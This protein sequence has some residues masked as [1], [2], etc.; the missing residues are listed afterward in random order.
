MDQSFCI[1]RL[2]A[3][4]A[5][6]GG[7]SD[8]FNGTLSVSVTYLSLAHHA[9]GH[10]VHGRHRRQGAGHHRQGDDHPPGLGGLA[11]Q[12]FLEPP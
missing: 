3:E 8:Q 12:A 11:S 10:L 4:V 9:H 6:L 5:F 7:L 2:E 1:I